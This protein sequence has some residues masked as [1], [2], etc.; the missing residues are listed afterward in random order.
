MPDGQDPDDLLRAGGPAA[1][2]SVLDSAMSLIDY[3]WSQAITGRN[4]KTPES[5]AAAIKAIR[6][7][8]ATIKTRRF[9][10]ITKR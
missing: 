1:L 5:R 8:I 3:L 9:S 6:I 4:F 2:K 10:A 7:Q